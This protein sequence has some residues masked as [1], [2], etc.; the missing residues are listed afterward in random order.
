M[1]MFYGMCPDNLYSEAPI[2][3]RFGKLDPDLAIATR[4]ALRCSGKV[5]STDGHD[6]QLVASY[7]TEPKPAIK[8]SPRAY[9]QVRAEAQ[10][11]GG[12]WASRDSRGLVQAM[13]SGRNMIPMGAGRR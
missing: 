3:T 8:L 9:R 13:T 6:T 4:R 7:W 2:F 11:F 12:G 10:L 1:A 5:Y